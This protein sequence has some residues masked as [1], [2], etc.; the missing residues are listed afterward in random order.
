MAQPIKSVEMY[1]TKIAY[2]HGLY[3]LRRI[4]SSP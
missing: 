2:L 4:T 3:P 1:A